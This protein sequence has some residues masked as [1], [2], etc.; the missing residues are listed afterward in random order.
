M[1]LKYKQTDKFGCGL[2]A[3]ANLFHLDNYITDERLEISKKGLV[4]GQLSKWLQ[5][6]GN[7]FYV[8]NW[9]YNHEGGKIPKKF[10]KYLP[11]ENSF[12][13]MFNVR[14]NKGLN[15][16]VAGRLYSD[17]K[18]EIAD[19]MKNDIIYLNN[20]S[21]INNL[22]DN[23]YGFFCFIDLE[24]TNYIQYLPQVSEGENKNFV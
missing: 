19:S 2:Y 22:Y 8:D 9:Y 23:V 16:I 1:I 24:N 7:N 5:D 10:F 21:E 4:I 20:F 12:P 3:I 14:S 13:V 11:A 6:D 17:G 15:H 18:L